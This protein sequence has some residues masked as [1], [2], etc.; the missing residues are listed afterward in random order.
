MSLVALIDHAVLHPLHAEGD[1]REACALCR[2]LGAASVCVKPSMVALAAECLAGSSV[3]ASTVIGF[4]HGGTASAVKVRETEL[5]V[6]SGAR[7]V[8]VVVNLGWAVEEQWDRLAAE[9]AAVTRAAAA[10]NALVKAILET[11][12][13]ADDATKIRLCAL[14]EAAG[15]AFVKTST[16]FGYATGADG[17]LR[18]TGATP[19][20]VALLRAHCGPTVGVKASGGIRTYEDARR[21]VDLGASRLGTSATR[22]IA[23]GERGLAARGEASY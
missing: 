13:L 9:L 8:D 16:G 22:A 15:A 14:S 18:A 19:H 17:T 11:G 5:A 4:P 3:V 6:E 23:D 21:L 1:V 7:E 12:L 2:E 20:D 10:G